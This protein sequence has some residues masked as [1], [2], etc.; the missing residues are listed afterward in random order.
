MEEINIPC[1]KQE[2]TSDVAT[3]SGK[4]RRFS[5]ESQELS[6]FA[7]QWLQLQQPQGWRQ[8]CASAEV[9][10]TGAQASFLLPPTWRTVMDLTGAPLLTTTWIAFCAQV[11]SPAWESRPL[12]SFLPHG[13]PSWTSQEPHFSS[14]ELGEHIV[15]KR[16]LDIC[17]AV[18]QMATSPE[19]KL[20]AG[21]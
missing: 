6:V 19:Y 17:G 14:Q 20:K 3:E 10:S 11:L 18:V 12:S 21:N 8:C 13:G 9:S 15:S 7:A 1:E 4:E 5:C 2:N 16:Y